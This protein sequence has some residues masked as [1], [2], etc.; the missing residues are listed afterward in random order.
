VWGVQEWQVVLAFQ[1]L[2][3]WHEVQ[4]WLVMH[5]VWGMMA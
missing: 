4:G 5:E 2:Q 3:E 1:E